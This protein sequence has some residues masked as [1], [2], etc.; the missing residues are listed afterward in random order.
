M[1]EIN[2]LKN[3]WLLHDKCKN[4]DKYGGKVKLNCGRLPVLDLCAGTGS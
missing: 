2:E 4:S 1:S 3:A